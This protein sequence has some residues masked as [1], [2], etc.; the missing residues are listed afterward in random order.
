MNVHRAIRLL[1]LLAFA[2]A[3]GLAIHRLSRSPEQQDPTHYVEAEV[4]GLLAAERP[5]E[6]RIDRLGQAPGLSPEEARKLLRDDVIPRLLKLKKG[7]EQIQTRTDET[8]KL[9]DEYLQVTD[10]LVNAC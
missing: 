10:Q 8:R 2:G 4:P 5:I 3:I 6:E 7:V 1:S 9:N